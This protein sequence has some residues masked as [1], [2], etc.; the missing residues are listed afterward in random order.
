MTLG[1]ELN[2]HKVS[3]S[4]FTPAVGGRLLKHWQLTRREHVLNSV[5]RQ[6]RQ[7]RITVNEAGTNISFW[8][9]FAEWAHES[10][11][12]M[13]MRYATS[14]SQRPSNAGQRC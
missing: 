8:T 13:T 5:V 11:S 14:P 9:A 7:I 10:T 2:I 3:V 4:Q 6:L 12:H 1:L